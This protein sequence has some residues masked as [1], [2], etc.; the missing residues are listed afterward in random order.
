VTDAPEEECVFCSI[1]AGESPA[2]FV[3]ESD[4]IVAFMDINPVTPGHLLVVPRRHLPDL[5]DVAPEVAAEMMLVAQSLAEALRSSP[6]RSEGV[7][8]FYADGE[9]AG[10]E[11]FHAHLHVFPRWEDDG[12]A[13]SRR[14]IESPRAD[15]DQLAANI[16]T[17]L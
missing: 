11:V 3:H 13:I 15:L 7:N 10:Q 14:I 17:G 9:A 1:A 2:S 12:F 8:L 4:R 5:A 16:R 6:V